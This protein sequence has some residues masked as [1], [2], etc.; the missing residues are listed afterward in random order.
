MIA[1]WVAEYRLS[2]RRIFT[3]FLVSDGVGVGLEIDRT[4]RI[5]QALLDMDNRV[6]VPMAGLR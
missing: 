5:F 6:R 2:L 4:A 1:G 3:L